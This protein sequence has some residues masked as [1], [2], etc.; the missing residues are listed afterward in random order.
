MDN[1]ES[2]VD[3]V[4]FLRARLDEDAAEIAKHPDDDVPD[5]DLIATAE[6]NYPCFPYIAIG[7]SRALAEVEAKR[8]IVERYH[9]EA[10]SPFGEKWRECA[11]C[12]AANEPW[13]CPTLRLLALPYAAHQ[14]YR[15]EWKP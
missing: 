5:W 4:T 3:L 9:Y 10:T 15:D 1:R 13:P 11:T 12:G 14:D 2:D 7:K 8:Q 6:T